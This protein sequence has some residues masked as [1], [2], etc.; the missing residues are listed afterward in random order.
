M[1]SEDTTSENETE[2]KEGSE[3]VGL[4]NSSEPGGN[5]AVSESE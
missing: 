3:R 2:N 5:S 4:L 1:I